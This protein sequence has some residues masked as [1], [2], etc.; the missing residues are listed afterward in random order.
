MTWDLCDR[1]RR[2][3][4]SITSTQTNKNSSFTNKKPSILH[5]LLFAGLATSASAFV[6]E[7][8]ARAKDHEAIDP[9]GVIA[10]ELVPANVT[11]KEELI[12]LP[13]FRTIQ[14]FGAS[15]KLFDAKSNIISFTESNDIV[16]DVELTFGGANASPKS[17]ESIVN[18]SFATSDTYA[19]RLEGTPNEDAEP[20]KLTAIL[21][22]GDYNSDSKTFTPASAGSEKAATAVSFTLTSVG[23]R[24]SMLESI[25]AVFKDAAGKVLDTQTLTGLQIP[26]DQTSRAAFFGF[27]TTGERIATVE[28][29]A[30]TKA[31]KFAAIPLL[32]LDDLGFAR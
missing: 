19:L 5:A 22:F 6:L 24:S 30:T 2:E 32:G 10:A 15:G 13:T 4:L 18:A 31:M 9:K 28:I 3:P 21:K 23:A 26:N 27:K 1:R 16:P 20:Q 11:T 7:N 14:I 25:E 8:P 12:A 29:T 17:G